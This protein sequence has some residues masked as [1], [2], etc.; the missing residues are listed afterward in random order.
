APFTG[1]PTL[2][3]YD[4]VPGGVGL[5]ERLFT[6]TDELVRACHEA[7]DSCGCKDGCPACVGP[8]I[9]VGH[10]GKAVVAELLAA[11]S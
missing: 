3:L 2:Y 11:M 1:R 6:L 8:A 9:E 4:A 10:R 5:T 7:V